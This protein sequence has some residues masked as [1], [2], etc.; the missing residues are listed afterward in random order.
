MNTIKENSSRYLLNPTHYFGA[1]TIIFFLI[2]IVT[3]AILV[4]NFIPYFTE[5]YQSL[6]YITNT[7]PYGFFI[8]TLH[9]YSAFGMLILCILHMARMFTTSRFLRPRDV[10]WTTGIVLLFFTALVTLT[11]FISSYDIWSQGLLQGFAELFNI[12]RRDFQTLLSVNYGL[13]L[14]LPALILMFLITHFS[15]IARPKVFPP[16][17]LTLVLLGVITLISGLFPVAQVVE[18]PTIQS[19]DPARIITSI[20]IF[21][22]VL[23]LLVFL[24]YI[25]RKKR[26][27]AFVDENRCTGCMYCSEACPKKAIEEKNISNEHLQYNIATVLRHK[28]QGCGICVGACRSSVIQLENH[29]DE[30][31]LEEVRSAWIE[32]A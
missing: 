3:G 8:R 22:A 21:S 32:Q 28:C 26:I 19:F 14:L 27:Y 13:H 9:R 15:R 18:D 25:S 1:I 4:M 24:P 31:M 16:L 7:L 2:Q 12:G 29:N 6:M 20:I 10:G 17:S 11:G 23:L 5:A 30:I